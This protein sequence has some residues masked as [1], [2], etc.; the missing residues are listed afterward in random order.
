MTSGKSV[1][2]S[3]FSAANPEGDSDRITVISA[4][5][6]F[7]L[8][9]FVA[10]SLTLPGCGGSGT[11]TVPVEGT[12]T[13][14]G[15]PVAGIG[16][17]F[18]PRQGNRPSQGYTDQSGHFKLNYT[19]HEEGA[20]R[21]THDVTFVWVPDREGDEASE[22]VQEILKRHGQDETPIQVEITEKTED[23]VIALPQE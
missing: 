2:W 22:A 12:V 9:V 7:L 5:V 4:P 14:Q 20:E 6:L 11:N 16:V 8:A 18:M 13:W 3:S 17:E 23:L 15:E 19:I 21:G 10:F 1:F